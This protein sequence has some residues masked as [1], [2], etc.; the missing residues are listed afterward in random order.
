MAGTYNPYL[1]L[2]S[3]SL[4]CLA[5]YT[6][7]DLA[8]RIRGSRRWTRLVWLATAAIAMGG[9]IWSMHFVGMLAF[10]MPM[11]VTYDLDLTILSLLVPIAV[12]GFGFFMI[13]IRRVREF[14]FIL[15]G[16]IM[17]IGIVAMH[18]TGMAA[19]RMPADISY[20]AV[21]VALSIAIAIGASVSALW[22]AFR[23]AI[24]WQRPL[25]AMVMGA[26][27]SG[28]HYTGMAAATFV[29]DPALGGAHERP[30]LAQTDLALAI[31]ALT[32]VILLLALVASAVDRK[33]MQRS[34]EVREKNQQLRQDRDELMAVYEQGLF[35]SH[36]NVEGTI[37]HANRACVED[38]GFARTDIV[39][40]RF[41]AARWW[42]QP[43][44]REWVRKAFEQAAAGTP[45]RGEVNYALGDGTAHVTDIAFV[46]IKDE[47]GHV[48]SVFVPGMDVTD[49]ARQY[50][51]TFEN[52]G[53][54]I[55]HLSPDIRWLRV[56]R[57]FAGIVGYSPEELVSRSVQDITHPDDLDTS[58]AEVERLRTGKVDSYELEKRYLRK[59]GT[60]VWVHI[61]GTA[62]RRNDGSV[63]HFVS[64]IQDISERRR[65]E[66][67][68][69]LL[70]REMNHRGKNILGLVQ[71]VARQTIASD[72]GS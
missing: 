40:R 25:S 68:V 23:T 17:G 36:C 59:D 30:G 4:A 61:T 72:P 6:A 71:A 14:E 45:F 58:A 15:S 28:M 29:A 5:S 39:G 32:F 26:A 19:M 63:D 62:V 56:N 42:Q 41:W 3:I 57:T 47:A 64:V 37:V 48:V 13:G 31:A 52:A 54:G 34:H 10:V 60:P 24:S 21:L 1:V 38:L 9:G 69:R 46:P 27:I 51:A 8:G 66:E 18:Y 44:T 20:D 53:V 33:L 12:T 70:M 65:A 2:L 50:R 49:R 35:A 7:L 22:L 67:Q 55:A 43:E 11:R 16:I